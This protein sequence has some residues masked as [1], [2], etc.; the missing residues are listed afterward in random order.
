MGGTLTVNVSLSWK[1]RGTEVGSQ[2]EK[3]AHRFL[4]FQNDQNKQEIQNGEIQL[5]VFHRNVAKVYLLLIQSLL[6]CTCLLETQGQCGR[7]MHF[8][9][10]QGKA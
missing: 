7:C 2:L 5:W 3:Y 8:S 4:P 10:S 6:I 9:T 1:G